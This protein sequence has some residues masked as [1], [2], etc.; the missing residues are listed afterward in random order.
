MSQEVAVKILYLIR[1]PP[2]KD[3]YHHLN[4]KVLCMYAMNNYRRCK[5]IHNLTLIGDT[6][7]TWT[8]SPWP[9]VLTRFFKEECPVAP[10]WTMSPPTLSWTKIVSFLPSELLQPLAHMLLLLDPPPP[11]FSSFLANRCSVPGLK[12][13][14]L[15]GGWIFS[16]CRF[17]SSS[18]VYIRIS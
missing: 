10:P 2:T 9:S 6:T 7:R 3:P 5:A 17:M 18:L 1:S 11:S 14:C 16:S 15:A 13:S 8:P 4:D 12:T